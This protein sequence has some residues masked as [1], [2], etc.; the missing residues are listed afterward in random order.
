[1]FCSSIR[2]NNMFTVVV[3]KGFF[4]LRIKSF[5]IPGKESLMKTSF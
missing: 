3:A 1:M 4:G 2:G 5:I